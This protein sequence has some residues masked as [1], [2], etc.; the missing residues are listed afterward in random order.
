M[1]EEVRTK[2][3]KYLYISTD[4]GRYF[5]IHPDGRIQRTD[6]LLNPSERW[7]MIGVFHQV[8]RRFEFIPL[9]QITRETG[10]LRNVQVMD[11]DCGTNRRWGDRV[12]NIVVF[13]TLEQTPHYANGGR[14]NL[15]LEARNA[16]T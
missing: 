1:S 13:D 16:R 5:I 6:M 15:E 12:T 9:D 2:D 14:Y 7:K 4:T 3:G 11:V 10:Q 8:K